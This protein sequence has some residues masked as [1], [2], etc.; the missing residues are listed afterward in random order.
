[1]S[2]SLSD[3]D[4]PPLF[5][6]ADKTA[7]DGQRSYLFLTKVRL[8]SS[9]LA[10]ATG[11]VTIK[12]HVHDNIVEPAAGFAVI[13]FASA[14]LCEIVLLSRRPERDWYDGR[15]LAESTKTLAWRYAVAAEPFPESMSRD[16]ARDLLVARLRSLQQS[17]PASPKASRAT[18]EA[19]SDAMDL[20]RTSDL[21]TRRNAYRDG[22]VAKQQVWYGENATKNQRRGTVWRTILFILELLGIILALLTLLDVTGFSAE[23]VIA[24][25]IAGS[26]AWLQVKQH[27]NLQRAYA[28]AA[29]ELGNIRSLGV[30]QL[31]EAQW[32]VYAA[33]AEEA[34]SREHTMWQASRNDHHL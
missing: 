10:A 7:A 22:R 21:E 16:K 30:Q 3:L 25:A 18:G 15:A 4:L 28:T 20:L 32:G 24:T 9:V 33:D 19:I 14:L 8:G 29:I 5:Q 23:G 27:D 12:T 6:A 11:L 26:G 31:T 17:S 1:M 13:F 2:L 34:I